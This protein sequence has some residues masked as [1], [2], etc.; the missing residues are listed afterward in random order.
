MITQGMRTRRRREEGGWRMEDGGWGR[1]GEGGGVG[2]GEVP[3][4]FV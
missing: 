4:Y 1:E 2:L 3:E